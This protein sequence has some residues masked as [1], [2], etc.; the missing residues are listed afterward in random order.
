MDKLTQAQQAKNTIESFLKLFNE[1]ADEI[2]GERRRDRLDNLRTKLQQLSP[3]V[4]GLVLEI[5]GNGAVSTGGTYGVASQAISHGALLLTALMGGHNETK[6]NFYEFKAPVTA[7]LNTA[8]GTIEAGIWPREEPNPI[9]VIKDSGLRSRC[10]DLLRAPTAYD[11]VI[12]EATTILEDRIRSKPSHATLARLIPQANDQVGENLVNKLFSPDNPV[13]VVSSERQ[14][15][16]SF[17]RIMLGVF[18]YLRNPYHHKLDPVTE[19]SWAWSTVGLIDRLLAE[20]EGCS[21]NE[22]I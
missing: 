18:S 13:L 8:L 5:V 16:A 19:W 2:F 20:I 4:T 6:Y 14:K 7:L 1:Y 21:V 3:K 12:R 17:H 10:L 11:R 22:R 9:L 15:Q